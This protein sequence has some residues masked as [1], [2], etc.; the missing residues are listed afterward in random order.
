MGKDSKTVGVTIE[1][2]LKATVKSFKKGKG[3]WIADFRRNTQENFKF[4]EDDSLEFD[5]FLPGD[6]DARKEA[7]LPG[8]MIYNFWI[9]PKYRIGVFLLSSKK[10]AIT[11]SA[12]LSIIPKIRKFMEEELIHWSWLFLFVEEASKELKDFIANLY[13]YKVGVILGEVKTRQKYSS[14][15]FLGKEGNKLLKFR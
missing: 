6:Q 12:I 13:S 9:N 7:R 8:A 11:K 2:A 14:S 5:Y 10:E 15:T 3:F 1:E 4:K